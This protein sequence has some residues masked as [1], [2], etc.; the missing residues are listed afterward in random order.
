MILFLSHFLSAINVKVKDTY[1]TWFSHHYFL[2]VNHLLSQD[3]LWVGIFCYCEAY[4]LFCIYNYD[5][6]DNQICSYNIRKPG[7]Y[8]SILFLQ[9]RVRL[10]QFSWGRYILLVAK[11]TH[12]SVW[13][14]CDNQYE[15]SQTYPHESP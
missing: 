11:E 5:H 10:F 4:H 8:Q 12:L 9:L 2:I 14:N 15:L 7:Q 3:I 6:Y 13:T 1:H